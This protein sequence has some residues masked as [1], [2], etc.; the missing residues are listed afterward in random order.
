[1]DILGTACDKII[2]NFLG[3]YTMKRFLLLVLSVILV[4]AMAVPSFA[5]EETTEKMFPVVG[6]WIL[7]AVYE[8][9]DG[10]TVLLE[11]SENQSYYGSGI[12]VFTF[13]DDGYAHEIT[14]DGEDSMDLAAQWKTTKPDVYV[15]TEEAGLEL[16]FNYD[17]KEDALHRSVSENPNLDFVYNRAVTGSWQLDKVLKIN[18]GDAPE[19]L[20]PEGAASLYAEKDNIITIYADGTVVTVVKDGE[21]TAEV[22]GTWKVNA[23]DTIVYTEG[24][25]TVEDTYSYFRV[26]DT[27][28]R[29]V[30]DDAP[31]AQY[32]HLQF[33][34]KRVIAEE[35]TEP[36]GSGSP[37]TSPKAG[38][39][40]NGQKDEKETAK[41]VEEENELI[42]DGQI[43][44]GFVQS[45]YDPDTLETYELKELNQGGYANEATG[46]IY[47]PEGGGGEHLYGNDGSVLLMGT[48]SDYAANDEELIADGQ[49]FT[50]YTM[51]VYDEQ[52]GDPV[53]L[54]ELN[55][56]GWANEATGE[57]FTQEA[58]GGDHLYGDRG[59]VLVFEYGNQSSI[60]NN[61]YDTD[62]YDDSDYDTEDID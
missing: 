57:V 25:D 12:T 37:S 31:D 19:E 48:P 59:T 11:K 16:S 62:D 32:P 43:F 51:T 21:D 13:D 15:F 34:Y 61:D 45:A 28:I 24:T 14:F 41:S 33:I 56:G 3:E 29:E 49:I 42:A 44:T 18:D 27:L 26:E 50:G 60:D 53:V 46:V 38:Q 9:K 58:G 35:K 6:S 8:S 5:A 10:Q 47:T 55:Q 1:M 36:A 39:P 4:M 23:A 52:T 22:K 17:E 7:N 54:S 40:E 30:T 2:K 20:K